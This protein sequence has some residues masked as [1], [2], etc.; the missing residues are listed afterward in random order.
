MAATLG[1]MEPFDVQND[2]WSPYTER[3]GQFFVA[4]NIADDKKKVAA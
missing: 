1:H 4:N 3:L 2:D